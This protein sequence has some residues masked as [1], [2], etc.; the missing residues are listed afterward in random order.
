MSTVFIIT[1]LILVVTFLIRIPVGFG[2]LIAC[3]FYFSASNMDI[4]L[5]ADIMGNKLY[6]MYVIIA[7][8]LFVFTANV[9]NT[10]TV[11][12]R[13]FNFANSL[14]GRY[15][16][17]M[18]HV[19]VAASLIFSG[20]T[21]SAIADASGLGKMEIRAMRKQGYDDGFS[22]AVTAASSTIGPIFPP[23]IPLV[24]YAMLSGA[25][26][27]ALFLAGIV[28]GLLL[29]AAL[30]I[31]IVF[32]ARKRDYPKGIH[33]SI[34]DFIFITIKAIPA[35]L[36][37]VILLGGIYTGVMTPTEAGAVAALYALIISVFA[38]RA[39]GIKGFMQV[40]VDTT[41][42]TGTL[43][44]ILAAAFPLSFIVAYEG[45][46][47]AIAE[48]MLNATDNKYVLLLIITAFFLLMGMFLDTSVLMLVF[49]PMVLPLV[50][51]MEIDLV[52]FGVIIVLNMMIGLSTP[53]FGMLLFIVSGISKTRLVSV[54]K[55]ILP[56]ICVM[57]VVLLTITFIPQLVLFI[58]ETLG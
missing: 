26:A 54:F 41:K 17:G 18:G 3:I 50:T 56:I 15:K 12:D 19:N 2:F 6:S 48:F 5:V 20:M 21:G 27:G 37:P 14:F 40:I 47:P 22:C 51:A 43:G 45:V 8:P 31:Y 30:M 53:P 33:Y 34:R 25:S 11:T 52:H 10:G 35:L 36:T 9:M 1:L 44:F 4:G 29:A 42:T 46:A 32:I 38:Y 57:I 13:V 16:G 55:E 24:I 58:P 28:P 7:V 39:L 49:I 23:S